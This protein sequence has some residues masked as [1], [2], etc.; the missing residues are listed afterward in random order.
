MDERRHLK[1]RISRKPTTPR[2]VDH[3]R[4]SLQRFV[5]ISAISG[6][7]WAVIAYFLASKGM[8]SIIVGGLLASPL[9]GIVVGLTYRPAYS[10]SPWVRLCMS[11]V[12]LYFAAALFGMATGV[13]DA[14]RPMP[15]RFVSEIVLQSV[16][17]TLW[18]LTFTGLFLFLWPLSFFNHWLVGRISG[19]SLHRSVAS[20]T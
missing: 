4:R 6:C 3:D 10:K 13:Y 19:L 17:A 9:I 18:G 14:M 16:I 8:G 11:F 2:M 15:T 5:L 1:I 20:R 12:T 7:I